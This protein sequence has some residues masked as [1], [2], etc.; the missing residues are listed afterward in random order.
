MPEILLD[1]RNAQNGLYKANPEV[2]QQSRRSGM[3]LSVKFLGCGAHEKHCVSP[4]RRGYAGDQ[5]VRQHTV[6]VHRAYPMLRRYAL[7]DNTAL[8][9][10][11]IDARVRRQQFKPRLERA[12]FLRARSHR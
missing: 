8:Q 6:R 9:V 12:H 4:I 5:R 7:H 1:G 11:D 2:P 3:S 10:S